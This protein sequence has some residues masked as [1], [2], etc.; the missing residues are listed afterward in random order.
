MVAERNLVWPDAV[1]SL[2]NL[3][4]FFLPSSTDCCYPLIIDPHNYYYPLVTDSDKL[5]SCYLPV[6]A[7]TDCC[8]PLARDPHKPTFRHLLPLA[9]LSPWSEVQAPT[10]TLGHECL[11][12]INCFIGNGCISNCFIGNAC[13]SNCFTGNGC[14]HY[15]CFWPIPQHW[16]DITLRVK[17]SKFSSRLN[18]FWLPQIC[19]I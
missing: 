10:A 9:I 12:F 16:F 19:S 18:V 13:I 3:L 2:N 4:S 1:Y 15:L 8:Y 11:Q 5:L 7:P 14:S 6:T 17:Y